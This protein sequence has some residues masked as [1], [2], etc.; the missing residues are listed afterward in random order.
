MLHDGLLDLDWIA[1][2]SGLKLTAAPSGESLTVF[3][4]ILITAKEK[5]PILYQTSTDIEQCF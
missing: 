5:S 1:K 3:F 2:L 4:S